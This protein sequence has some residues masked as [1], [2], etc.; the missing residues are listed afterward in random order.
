MDVSLFEIFLA[1]KKQVGRRHPC[2]GLGTQRAYSRVIMV[3]V[4]KAAIWTLVVLAPG[5][6][7]LLPFLLARAMRRERP[8]SQDG[9]SGHGA[10]AQA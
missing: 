3:W 5:G 4:V 8:G 6:V 1:W 9:V 10:A 7:L 2:Q